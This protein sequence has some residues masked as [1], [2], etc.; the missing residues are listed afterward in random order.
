MRIKDADAEII[1]AHLW[2]KPRTW[3]VAHGEQTLAPEQ[4]RQWDA[5]R[6]RRERGEPVAYITGEKEFFGRSFHVDRSVLIPRPSTEGLVEMVLALVRE[7]SQVPG[8]RSQVRVLD[9]D[10]IGFADIWGSFADTHTIVD[11]GTGSGCIAI[12]I[13][14]ELP[15]ISII[16]TDTSAAALNIA[17]TN[18]K[19]HGVGERIRFVQGNLLEP[20]MGTQRPFLLV[21]NPPYIPEGENL[22][23]DVT[24]YEPSIALRAGPDGAAVLRP[25]IAAARSHP[26]CRGFVVECR[27]DQIDKKTVEV[28]NT[29]L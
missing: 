5:F 28:D 4:E 17:R 20:V 23:R 18:A 27:E 26:A 24:A 6:R 21:S 11:V 29:L 2:G 16:A 10:I 12:T 22:P 14:C 8:P 3:I 15:E 13:A 7:K 9:T 19:R 25:L 1:L